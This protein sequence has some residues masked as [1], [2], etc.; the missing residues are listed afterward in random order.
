MNSH[1][2]P[3]V[4]VYCL[5]YVFF[6][7]SVKPL[8]SIVLLPFSAILTNLIFF[9]FQKKNYLLEAGWLVASQ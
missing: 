3:N 1:R 9:V 2:F 8:C 7:L 4:F 6:M 5:Q